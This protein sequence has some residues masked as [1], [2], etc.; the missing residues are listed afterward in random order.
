MLVTEV[1]QNPCRPQYGVGEDA[2]TRKVEFDSPNV[3]H[4]LSRLQLPLVFPARLSKL[5]E[6]SVRGNMASAFA[7]FLE[8]SAAGRTPVLDFAGFR[9]L[10]ARQRWARVALGATGNDTASRRR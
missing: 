6:L 7:F 8:N 9:P 1:L 5:P 10:F 2:P 3:E 4:T